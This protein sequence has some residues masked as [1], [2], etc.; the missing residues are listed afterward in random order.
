MNEAPPGSVVKLTAD[1][2]KSVFAKVLWNMNDMQ[3]NGELNFRICN[4][5]ANA[6]GVTDS[7]FHLMVTYYE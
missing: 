5:A 7:K 2:G 1:D 6:L 3:E 4:T